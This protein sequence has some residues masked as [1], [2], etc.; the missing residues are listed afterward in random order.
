MEAAVRRVSIAFA[1]PRA[2]TL[3]ALL[4][5]SPAGCD[6]VG[7]WRA[8]G[9]YDDY[10]EVLGGVISSSAPGVETRSTDAGATAESG[11]DGESGAGGFEGAGFGGGIGAPD[12]RSVPG[13]GV[14]HFDDC[15]SSSNVLADSSG[16]G[17]DARQALGAACVPGLSGQGV[18]IRSPADVIEVP[19]EPQFAVTSR[20]AVAAWINPHTVQ[21]LQ[22]ILIR[23]LD[24]QV[25]F[26]LE[27]HDG[28][29]EMS[30]VLDDGTSVV[31][32]APISAGV[33]T[34]VAGVFD[35][36]FLALFINGQQVGQVYAAGTVRPVSAPIQIG[37][38]SPAQHFDGVIDE[39]FVSTQPVSASEITEMSC[40]GRPATVAFSPEVSGPVAAGTSAAFDI[41]VT[42]R[43]LGSC[44]ASR[45]GFG[46]DD[47]TL[48]R[49]IDV[50][51]A[52]CSGASPPP[53]G[54]TRQ[55]RI[56]V[57]S[58]EDV[59]PGVHRIPIKFLSLGGSFD[60]DSIELVYEIATPADCFVSPQQELMITNLSVVN[61]P[62]RTAGNI[63]ESDIDADDQQSGVVAGV[64]SFAHLMRELAPTPGDAP[65]LVEQWLQL[66]A[67][68]QSVNG[69][70]VAARPG[71]RSL[72]LDTWPR[73][74]S[75]ALDLDRAP[76]ALQAIVNRIDLRDLSLGSA[77]EGRFVFT[78]N[79]DTGV[80]L[81]FTLMLDYQLPAR[82]E[83]DVLTW[84][85][86]W[87]ELQIHPLR[88][89]EYGAALEA[90][91]GRFTSRGAA[92]DRVNGSALLNLRTNE[93]DL[94]RRAPWQLRQFELSAETGLLGQVP[95]PGTP[96]LSLNGTSTFANFVNQTAAASVGFLPGGSANAV[97]AEFEGQSFQA[98]AILNGSASFNSFDT[99]SAPGIVDPEARFRVALNTCNGCHSPETD[100][101]VF[102][103]EA[104]DGGEAFLSFFIT[105][106]TVA[107]PV[108]GQLRTFNDLARRKA[109]LASL[110]CRTGADP[111]PPS[112]DAG[113]PD[114][115]APAP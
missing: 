28:N 34:Q 27:I 93:K 109:D 100:S 115:S 38:A 19:D 51:T 90:V 45:Y 70:T 99:W 11:I 111:A 60:R 58:T 35:G 65:A 29:I 17:A 44:R 79:D 7:G 31:L 32:R 56:V 67:S 113:A 37:G 68:A 97:P 96:D 105:G 57:S 39:V 86:L 48:D 16:L 22:P 71:I 77:G 59:E 88:S 14:W 87:H 63:K 95:L 94:G 112:P 9:S 54:E 98:G 78:V 25:S 8:A 15:S 10:S 47:L 104:G 101:G 5:A 21:G 69:F 41:T 2:A 114:A 61:D 84:A 55:C 64:W 108:T 75:G 106:T 76:V 1:L 12:A 46:W 50:D 52:F 30:V 110:V 82:T 4:L 83:Q 66:F 18:Q 6:V 103:I 53:P 73:T 102:Q 36:T 72:V 33:F 13:S 23:R 49:G 43:D 85:K 3:C 80:P 107:D 91:T 89:E 26:A 42:N 81:N 20:L 40:I 24:K 74:E 62:I 92:P